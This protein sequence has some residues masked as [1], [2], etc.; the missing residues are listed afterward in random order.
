MPFLKSSIEGRAI[1]GV[2]VAGVQVW[3]DANV[4]EIVLIM[5]EDTGVC[6][7]GG[8]SKG[9]VSWAGLDISGEG[10]YEFPWVEGNIRG[11]A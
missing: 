11:A 7:L 5:V 1:V 9:K 8:N 10:E 3:V 2:G 4:V 6:V